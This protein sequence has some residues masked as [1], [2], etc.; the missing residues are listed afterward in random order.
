MI[1]K[2]WSK[3]QGGRFRCELCPRT[4]LLKPGQK[5]FCYVREAK[6][7]GICLSAYGRSSGFCIDPIEKKPL[8]HFLP[9]SKILSF[10]TIGCNLGCKFCQNWRIS[11]SKSEALLGDFI[12]PAQ[13]AKAAKEAGCASVAFTYNEPVISAEYV[14]DA[15]IEC[16]RQGVRTVAVSAGYISDCARKEFFEVL[17]AVNIDLKGFSDSF[18]KK[19]SLGHLKPVL[20]TLEYVANKT[21]TWL[22]VT[23]LVIPEANDSEAEIDSMTKWLASH[24]GPEVPLHFSAFHPDHKLTDRPRTPVTTLIKA[25]GIAIKNGLRHV[26]LGNVAPI[27]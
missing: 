17:D 13:V 12:S 24:L 25:R 5:G 20:D 23:N 9:G 27:A 7:D 4:C 2:W 15:A 6:E 11:K 26:Y 22:E 10:G 14:I 18:Y 8:Y 21:D 3:T 16:R 19:Y 1:A